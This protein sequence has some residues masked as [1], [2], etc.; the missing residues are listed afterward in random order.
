MGQ[1]SESWGTSLLHA[2]LENVWQAL[3]TV[4][5]KGG[6]EFLARQ[7]WCL[8]TAY[9]KMVLERDALLVRKVE[10]ERE[11]EDVRSCF[12]IAQ[13]H[14]QVLTDQVR[15]YQHVA[16][17]AAMWVA[18]DKYK[19]RQGK[20]NVRKVQ[21]ALASA[22]PEWD[23]DTRNGDIWDDSEPEDTKEDPGRI[24][25][26]EERKKP[27]TEAGTQPQ[28]R[29]PWKDLFIA[30]W[31]AGIPLKE[32][33]GRETED[34]WRLYKQ[35]GLNVRKVD[36]QTSDLICFTD[37]LDSTTPLPLVSLSIPNTDLFDSLLAQS[38]LTH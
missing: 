29:P 13:C 2:E 3:M 30:L 35:K 23:P 15:T 25:R 18:E 31:R 37:P 5:G 19:G 20:V 11:L 14:S 36:H 7:E 26:R 9:K 4:M 22:G 16:E 12:S 28:S 6:L 38:R 27:V 10:L 33:D 1:D 8:L 21:L 24:E 32:L 17:T 34:L